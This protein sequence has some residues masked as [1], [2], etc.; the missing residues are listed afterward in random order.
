LEGTENWYRALP[1]TLARK[2]TSTLATSSGTT[3]VSTNSEPSAAAP[4]DDQS[5]ETLNSNGIN[6]LVI[7]VIVVSIGL[8]I[9]V[10]AFLW[11]NAQTRKRKLADELIAFKL[12]KLL[13]S[14]SSPAIREPVFSVQGLQAQPLYTPQGMMVYDD[15]GRPMWITHD[16]NG[17]PLFPELLI[18]HDMNGM[19][20]A[21]PQLVYPSP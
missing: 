5:S 1:P 12:E 15:Q 20:L 21:E 7:V 18:T 9:G 16:S 4:I 8:A 19:L 14:P 6:P 17:N 10:A 3:T 13:P 2:I 11:R